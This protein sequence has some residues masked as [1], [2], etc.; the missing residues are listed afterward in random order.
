[1]YRAS[2]GFINVLDGL[3]AGAV[4][5]SGLEG[6][7]DIQDGL[8]RVLKGFDGSRRVLWVQGFTL[9]V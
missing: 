6:V 1:M 8:I 9:E 7:Q 2:E 4:Y 3:Y 5:G